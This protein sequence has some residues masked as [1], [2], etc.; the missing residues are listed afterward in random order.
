MGPG[1]APFNPWA[2]IKIVVPW[3]GGSRRAGS[4]AAGSRQRSGMALVVSP[5]LGVGRGTERRTAALFVALGTSSWLA[6]N[7]VF[8]Q[9]PVF[10][11][12]LPEGAL[13]RLI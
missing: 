10:A 12:A 3:R 9:L 13:M 8:A 7:A 2:H 11:A 6:V 1:R 5:L 4:A